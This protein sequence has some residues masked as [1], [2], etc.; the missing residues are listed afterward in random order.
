[1]QGLKIFTSQ[2]SFSKTTGRCPSPI[3]GRKPRKRE[4]MEFNWKQI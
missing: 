1:M 4:I 2:F 3:C